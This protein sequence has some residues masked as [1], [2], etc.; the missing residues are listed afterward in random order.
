MAFNNPVRF[1][2]AT[3][4]LLTVRMFYLNGPPTPPPSPHPR[5]PSL[6]PRPQSLIELR[7]QIREASINSGPDNSRVILD[8][9]SRTPNIRKLLFS[10]DDL[11]IRDLLYQ[12]WGEQTIRSKPCPPLE[13]VFKRHP[14]IGQE[15]MVRFIRADSPI[16]GAIPLMLDLAVRGNYIEAYTWLVAQL[17]ADLDPSLL[18]E[19]LQKILVT[20]NGR[21]PLHR[22][23]DLSLYDL[24]EVLARNGHAEL[25]G[26]FNRFIP[27]MPLLVISN[28]SAEHAEL[29]QYLMFHSS[30]WFGDGDTWRFNFYSTHLPTLVSGLF[31]FLANAP[32]LQAEILRI[33]PGIQGTEILAGKTIRIEFKVDRDVEVMSGYTGF[34]DKKHIKID[35]PSPLP[36]VSGTELLALLLQ[37]IAH[38]A[39]VG[40]FLNNPLKTL[41]SL[42]WIRAAAL[43]ALGNNEDDF[44]KYLVTRIQDAVPKEYRSEN[45]AKALVECNRMIDSMEPEVNRSRL[46]PYFIEVVKKPSASVP[47]YPGEEGSIYELLRCM[48][49]VTQLHGKFAE[50]LSSG[51]DPQRL[52]EH[53]EGFS[54]VNN[55]KVSAKP[56]RQSYHP[57]MEKQFSA[58][59]EANN[60]LGLRLG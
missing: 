55:S 22:H 17:T 18:Q 48:I 34:N 60:S 31:N 7:Q 32:E 50:L 13:Y 4:S 27:T 28:I 14:Q 25:W 30:I 6:P 12:C 29:I 37:Q 56:V 42:G 52:R 9:L 20:W 54:L 59:A 16:S 23:G 38:V 2:L 19:I 11:P 47:F 5:P 41:I 44:L 49:Y 35:V 33:L 24:A 39:D 21:G 58:S 46:E 10:G 26:L 15:W 45:L 3:L 53:F 40:N 43:K 57:F 8:I 51:V 1:L 36:K